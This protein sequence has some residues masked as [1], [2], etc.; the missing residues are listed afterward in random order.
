MDAELSVQKQQFEL[1]QQEMLS[2]VDIERKNL[3]LVD[4][5]VANKSKESDLRL[6]ELNET[7]KAL[8][9]VDPA[10]IQA[11]SMG[12]IG[13]S[14]LIAMAF[15]DLAKSAAKINNLNISP[16]L[17]TALASSNSRVVD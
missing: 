1:E 16:D 15:G 9:S 10:V 14:E 17:L 2:K 11:L 12:K 3:E 8:A 7:M 4:L 5:S 6:K 13:S